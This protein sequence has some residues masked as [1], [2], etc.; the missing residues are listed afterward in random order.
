MNTEY[1]LFDTPYFHQLLEDPP[2]EPFLLQ[3]HP[4]KF[5]IINTEIQT[6]VVKTYSNVSHSKILETFGIPLF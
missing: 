4:G 6:P 1:S 5:I 3:I 2:T